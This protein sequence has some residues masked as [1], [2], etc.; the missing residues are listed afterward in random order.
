MSGKEFTLKLVRVDADSTETTVSQKQVQKPEFWDD[1]SEQG[2]RD[3]RL[4]KRI[5]GEEK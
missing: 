3:E 4:R 2:A 1:Q 5:T